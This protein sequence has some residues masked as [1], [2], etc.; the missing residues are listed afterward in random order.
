MKCEVCG[1]ELREDVRFCG[2]CGAPVKDLEEPDDSVFQSA[3]EYDFGPEYSEEAECSDEPESGAEN[4]ERSGGSGYSDASDREIETE[5]PERS[6]RRTERRRPLLISGIVTIVLAVILVLQ[7]FAGLP[8][9]R[10][11]TGGGIP[12]D[13]GYSSPE[14]LMEE[15]GKAIAANDVDR[16]VSLFAVSHMTENSDFRKQIEYMGAWYLGMGYPAENSIFRKTNAICGRGT[17]ARQ[18]ANLCFS[19]EAK[20]EYLQMTPLYVED[21]GGLDTIISDIQE[22]AQLDALYTF[23][24]VRVDAVPYDPESNSAR[25]SSAQTFWEEGAK[26]YGADEMVEYGVLYEY[27]GNTYRGAVSMVRY[28]STYYIQNLYS[29]YLG[30]GYEGYLAQMDEEQY[31]E[32]LKSS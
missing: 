14:K 4:V 21:D 1:S 22:A 7:N 15:F 16:A 2:K 8:L 6:A 30:W 25:S 13:R 23:R 28:G 20:E 27:G 29:S 17:A 5:L 26:F 18:I 32:L 19:L 11:L 3:G 24:V 9:V 31:L 10:E 12:A